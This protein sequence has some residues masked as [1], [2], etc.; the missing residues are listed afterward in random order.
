MIVGQHYPYQGSV[1]PTLTREA[2]LALVAEPALGGDVGQRDAGPPEQGPGSGEAL[3][4]D[5]R[6]V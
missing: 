4:Y 5:E 1:E 2:V 3:R 6:E